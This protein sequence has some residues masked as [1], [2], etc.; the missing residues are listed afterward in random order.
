ML[1]FGWL[2]RSNDSQRNCSFVASFSE[3]SFCSARS[4]ACNPGPTTA[5]RGMFPKVNAAGTENTDLSN[6][7]AGS[8]GP[9]LGSAEML[10]RCVAARPLFAG[11]D[12]VFTV[13]GAPDWT[14]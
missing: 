5:L 6:H 14:V 10:G 7:C 8:F 1:K 9:A 12:E 13:K 2:N 3:K 4:K 11:S